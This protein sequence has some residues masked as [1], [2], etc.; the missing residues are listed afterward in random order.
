M[1]LH[2]LLL[3]ARSYALLAIGIG[4]CGSCAKHSFTG[5]LGLY[6]G[7]FLTVSILVFTMGTPENAVFLHP[8]MIKL[9][10]NKNACWEGGCFMWLHHLSKW[11]Q[12]YQRWTVTCSTQKA[13]LCSRNRL[14]VEFKLTHMQ[15]GCQCEA[16][17]LHFRCGKLLMWGSLTVHLLM[18]GPA[19]AKSVIKG[20]GVVVKTCIF[21][22][23]D[24]KMLQVL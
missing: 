10:R 22:W 24:W 23:I 9:I 14:S 2:T 6:P 5:C 1:E 16:H 15:L 12:W 8:G 21:W 18:Q 20:S 19:T 13:R 17:L 11:S 7:D 4:A 3:A